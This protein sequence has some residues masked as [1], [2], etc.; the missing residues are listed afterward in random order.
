MKILQIRKKSGG[1]RTVYVPEDAHKAYLRSILP[2]LNVLQAKFL[3]WHER[4]ILQGMRGRRISERNRVE[5]PFL[6]GF[7]PGASPVSNALVHTDYDYTLSVDIKDCFDST[8]LSAVQTGC[9]S[10]IQLQ[11]FLAEQQWAMFEQGAARQGLPTS[12]AL[13]NIALATVDRTLLANSHRLWQQGLPSRWYRDTVNDRGIAFDIHDF[14]NRS[15]ANRSV[16]ASEHAWAYTRYADDITISAN[17]E[18]FIRAVMAGMGDWVATTC[19]EI[20]VRKTRLQTS[21]FG[22]RVITGVAVDVG[23]AARRATRRKLRAAEHQDN[24]SSAEGLK[25]W[26]QLKLP[27]KLV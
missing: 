27:A 21:R 3:N 1:I 10:D 4:N 16:F 2:R 7:L 25:A 26:S 11:R 5:M 14:L 19:F 6:H 8:S 15:V 24:K 22:K 23:I 13:A 9:G 18:A 12:P 17:S 20:N